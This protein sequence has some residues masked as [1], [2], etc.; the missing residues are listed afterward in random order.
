MALERLTQAQTKVS[1]FYLNPLLQVKFRAIFEPFS[2][3]LLK[4]SKHN[5]ILSRNYV[6]HKQHL[7]CLCWNQIKLLFSELLIFFETGVENRV[8]RGSR[9]FSVTCVFRV[10]ETT[11]HILHSREFIHWTQSN[12]IQWIMWD[13][14][15]LPHLIEYN[16][17]GLCSV[18]FSLICATEF[19]W[20]GNQT[21][22]KFG[23]WFG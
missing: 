14:V 2:Y 4:G 11:W 9:C 16:L 1:F 17:N 22:R 10:C 20:F 7:G 13:W 3:I 12:A 15:W 23:V 21:G 6:N 5:V 19:D 18:R 8:F